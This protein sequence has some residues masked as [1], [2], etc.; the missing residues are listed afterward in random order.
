MKLKN[1]YERNCFGLI[2]LE[3]TVRQ[4]G[5]EQEPIFNSDSH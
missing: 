4:K 1:C 3:A 2:L 5:N